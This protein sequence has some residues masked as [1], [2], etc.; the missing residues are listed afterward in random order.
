[1]PEAGVATSLLWSP[2]TVAV[3][4]GI[5]AI[6]VWQALAPA[7]RR[8]L[9]MRLHDYVQEDAAQADELDRPFTSRVLAPGF[10]G[11]LRGLGRILPSRNAEKLR[12]LLLYAGEPGGLSTLDFTGLRMLLA[13]VLGGGCFWF[14]ARHQP[15]GVQILATLGAAVVGYMLPFYWLRS[16]ARRRQKEIQR[17]LPDALDMLTISVEAGLAFETGLLRV[18]EQ[19]HNALSEEFRRVVGEMRMGVTRSA[20]FER[21]VARTDVEELATFVAV[22]VQSTQLGVSIAQV[23]HTQA[24]QMRERRQQRA[25]ELA[26]QASVKMVLVLVLF[27]FPVLFIVLLGPVLPQLFGVLDQMKGQ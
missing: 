3:L 19:W 1:M 27:F 11:I 14:F 22:L 17:A 12:K 21:L 23:L 9:N 16:R 10:H 18:G 7:Q 4:T 6:L 8:P 25:E 24:A 20:A 26:R 13:L 5:A 2:V 15:A